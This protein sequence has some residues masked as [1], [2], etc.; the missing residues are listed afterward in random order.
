MN[1]TA[2]IE[3]NHRI[4]EFI[5]FNLHIKSLGI[6]NRRHVFIAVSIRR[7]IDYH[8]DGKHD[9]SFSGVDSDRAAQN[10]ILPD[11]VDILHLAS[12][13]V[14]GLDKFTE[15]LPIGVQNAADKA[16]FEFCSD[17]VFVD[18]RR[19]DIGRVVNLR[20]AVRAGHLSL[21]KVTSRSVIHLTDNLIIRQIIDRRDH[22]RF[23]AVIHIVVIRHR[24]KLAGLIIS[25]GH[26]FQTAV[27]VVLILAAQSV[28]SIHLKHGIVSV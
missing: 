21:E 1:H 16:V 3:I 4:A 24:D 15:H 14:F 10:H 26:G 23:H 12:L 13:R 8:A 18:M 9:S 25:R 6:G 19:Q 7:K 22:T 11:H 28:R 20:D 27:G 2:V 5:F 17:S